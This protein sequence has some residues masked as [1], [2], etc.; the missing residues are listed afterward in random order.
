M[1]AADAAGIQPPVRARASPPRTLRSPGITLTSTGRPRRGGTPRGRPRRPGAARS[2]EWRRGGCSSG[3][4]H[5]RRLRRNPGRL[6]AVRVSTPG[7]KV[8]PGCSL[9]SSDVAGSAALRAAANAA[10]R[11]AGPPPSPPRRWRRALRPGSGR[12]AS[13]G[14]SSLRR[15]RPGREGFLPSPGPQK[16]DECFWRPRATKPPDDDSCT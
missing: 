15:E 2:P 9:M 7:R 4:V 12:R 5:R 10:P 8:G 1:A 11:R 6:T 3:T 13:C 14:L 16:E